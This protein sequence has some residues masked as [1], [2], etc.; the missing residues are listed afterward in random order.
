LCV[1]HF[2]SYALANLSVILSLPM[3][4]GS[5]LNP[6]F[7]KTIIFFLILLGFCDTV[8]I[9]NW[10]VNSVINRIREVSPSKKMPLVILHERRGY[11]KTAKYPRNR[12][13]IASWKS[14][15]CLY[16]TPRG[17]NDDW[18]QIPYF[19]FSFLFFS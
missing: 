1:I 7:N 5:G 19:F 3:L 18:Y 11:D 12:E 15:G 16:L 17:S 4:F 14:S 9:F 6:A 10:K 13:M 8:F 2:D